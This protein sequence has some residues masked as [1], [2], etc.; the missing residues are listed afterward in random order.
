MNRMSQQKRTQ[1]VGVVALT[2][3]SLAGI[4]FFLIS[5]QRSKLEQIATRK[6]R[7]QK[8]FEQV[9][10]TIRNAQQIDAELAEAAELLEKS[11]S[12][13]AAGDLYS[14]AINT[15]REFKL[16]YKVEI[17]QF[18]QIEGPRDT[19]LLPHFPYKQAT[20]SISG[21]AHF[22]DFGRFVA[23]M[24]NQFPYVRL[25]NMNLE[26]SGGA[27]SEPERLTFKLDVVALVKPSNS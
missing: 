1:L 22:F 3:L 2:I 16:P 12:G 26:P 5:A 4:W 8:Q 14:W 6:D 25:V 23:D 10:A 27:S 18:S 15:I 21:S 20:L 19:T 24:E 9:T 7:L 11:E 13:M 17:P